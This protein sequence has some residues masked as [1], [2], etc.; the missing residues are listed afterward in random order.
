MMTPSRWGRRAH[1]DAARRAIAA[2][3][4]HQCAD[5]P[6]EPQDFSVDHRDPHCGVGMAVSGRRLAQ[7]HRG[8]ASSH[9]LAGTIHGVTVRPCSGSLTLRLLLSISQFLGGIC[10]IHLSCCTSALQVNFATNDT[11]KLFNWHPFLMALAFPL[12]MGEALLAYRAPLA[13]NLSV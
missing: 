9:Y 10:D 5:V 1:N 6:T 3:K 8:K 4:W 12:L 11:G 2:W 7:A 13:Q